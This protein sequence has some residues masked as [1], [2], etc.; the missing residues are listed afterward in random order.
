MET[1]ELKDPPSADE[2]ELTADP[3]GEHPE[4][5]SFAELFESRPSLTSRKK[6]QPGD[7]VQGQVVLITKDTVFVDFGYKAEG[8]ASIDDFV[9]LE[10]RATIAV[11]SEV[12][13]TVIAFTPTGVHLGTSL[14]KASGTPGRELVQRAY[15]ADLPVEG[16]ILKVNKGG[17]EVDIGGARAFCPLSQID[18]HYCENPEAL[19]G[20]NQ[21]F[22]VLRIEEDGRNVLLS[23]RAVL[24]AEREAQA[25]KVRETLAIGSVLE[26]LVTRLTPFGA[27]V[28]L[29]GLEGLL[30]ISEISRQQ[31]AD[32]ADRLQTGQS[33]RVQVLRLEQGEKGE[34]RVSL[35]MK[36]LEPDP[37]QEELPFQEGAL[38]SGQVRH[39][40]PYGAFVELTPGLEGLIHI[41]EIS[42]RRISH[43]KQVLSPGETVTVM[44]LEID[45]DRQRVSL[46]LK[47]AAPPVEH[48]AGELSETRTGDVIRRGRRSEDLEAGDPDSSS[49][50]S[51]GMEIPEDRPIP[52]VPAYP[53][54]PR[55]GLVTRGVV[56]S[57]KPYGLFLDLPELG[58]RVR[59]L[60]H[61]SN[62]AAYGGASSLRGLKEGEEMEVEII[63]IDEQ[64]RISLSQQSVIENRE[65]S[66]LKHYLGQDKGSSALGTM[67]DLFKK[68]N[69]PK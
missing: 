8:R 22:Q 47:A 38:V 68:F 37:W 33:V 31:V 21:K 2:T 27:F 13:L 45:R 61:Q 56:S 36:S 55:V 16:M 42:D 66:E 26:G 15:E 58:S 35:S 39:L 40:T 20:T 11:G 24:Q 54:K 34:E 52:P 69:K 50:A 60:L 30:H 48:P 3:S 59:G 1:T 25:A 62:L 51:A 23:R 6:L 57:V 43:P 5:T 53:L 67:A 44:I 46:S 63:K 29:G 10:G 32:P 18:I 9:D 19:V 49:P 12:S 14:R 65:R 4:E 41:S 7:T 64:G 28:D 17:L